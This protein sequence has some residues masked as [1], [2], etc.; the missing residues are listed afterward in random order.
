MIKNSNTTR[1]ELTSPFYLANEKFCLNFGQYIEL[2]NGISKGEYNAWG[3]MLYGKIKSP[4]KWVFKYK[5]ATFPTSGS[6]FISAEKEGL[7][8]LS[9]WKTKINEHTGANFLIRTRQT[10]D[11]LNSKVNHFE[12]FTNYVIVSN[13]STPLFF[14]N[15]IRILTPL[16]TT[17]QIYE[18]E[19]GNNELRIELRSKLHNF[20]VLD[21]LIKQI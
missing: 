2:K 12:N 11:R 19:Y 15:L 3:Y 6:L 21:N 1:D 5:K 16:F 9:E 13:K 14:S 20:S 10:L 17:G 7:L 8:V 18:I 4:K